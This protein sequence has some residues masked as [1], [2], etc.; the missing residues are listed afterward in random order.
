MPIPA[1]LCRI[2]ELFFFVCTLQSA[3]GFENVRGVVL[4][5]SMEVGFEL[6]PSLWIRQ[7]PRVGVEIE[8]VRVDTLQHVDITSELNLKFHSKVALRGN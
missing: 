2:F 7:I 5:V 8:L 3:G 6:A 4:F 1:V